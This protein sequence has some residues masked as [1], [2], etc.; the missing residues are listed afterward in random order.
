MGPEQVVGIL[1]SVQVVTIPS[2]RRLAVLDAAEWAQLI[3]W[4]EEQED[5]RIV[6]T[7]LAKLRSGPEVAGA[8]PLADVLD[9]F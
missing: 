6:A 1:T 9:A 5:K 7:T 2:G 8:L 4:L 3:E